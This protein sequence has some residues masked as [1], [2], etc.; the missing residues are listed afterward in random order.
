MQLAVECDSQNERGEMLSLLAEFTEMPNDIKLFRLSKLMNKAEKSKERREE[1]KKI[2]SSLPVE[3][4]R[5][6]AKIGMSH[7]WSGERHQCLRERKSSSRC[8]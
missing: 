7:F 4:V 2:L 8:C 5:L 1:F 6:F 3:L